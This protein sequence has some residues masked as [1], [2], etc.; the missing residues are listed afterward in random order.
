MVINAPGDK[1]F[2]SILDVIGRSDVKDDPRFMTRSARV[3][4]MLQLD[5]L[6]EDWTS[7]HTKEEISERLL[8]ASVPCAPVREL[9]E[10]VLD[11]NMHARGSLQWVDHPELGRVVLPHTPLQFQG[12]ARADLQPSAKLGQ[13]N[14]AIFGT[15]LGH[16]DDELATLVSEGV[17]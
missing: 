8:A 15:W 13:D 9:S 10:V 17:I 14:R 7:Q 3:G 11:R 16:S 12:T 2:R 1:H 4:N 5:A 6:L